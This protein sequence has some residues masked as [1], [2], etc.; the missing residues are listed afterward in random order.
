VKLLFDVSS[1][2]KPLT[3]IGR[4]ALELAERLPQHEA[5][6]TVVFVDNGRVLDRFDRDAIGDPVPEGRLRRR[7]R[8][9]LPYGLALRPYRRYRARRQA[10]GLEPYSDHVYFSPNFTLPPLAGPG[11]ATLHDLSVYHYPEYHPRDRVNFLRDQIAHSVDVADCLVTDSEFVRSELLEIFSLPA[12]RVRAIPLGVDSGY[13]PRGSEELAR[14]MARY[15]LTAGQYLLSVGTLEPRKN[16]ERLLQAYTGLD[17]GLRSSYPLVIVGGYGWGSAS[18][19]SEMR[20]LGAT[21]EVVYL[22]YVPERDLPCLYAGATLF[23]YFSLYEGF[24]LP[25]LEAMSSG[26][27]V[28]CSDASALSELCPD[29]D[30]QADPR[31]AGAIR[32]LLEKALASPEWRDAA[33]HRGRARSLGYRWERTAGELVDVLAAVA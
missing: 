8:S 31:D 28:L 30:A 19:V 22:D 1:V 16:L 5:V 3:G 24:G 21:G 6:E 4:Y 2:A 12:D 26:V 11:V 10:A 13:R 29:R 23:C 9:L 25:V 33:G 32:Q 20:R 15:G 17:A 14:P 27:P 7:L 18:L